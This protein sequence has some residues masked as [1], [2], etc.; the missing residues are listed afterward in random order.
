LKDQYREVKRAICG[1]GE[2]FLTDEFSKFAVPRD[3]WYDQT[4]KQREK[5][6][7]KFQ[8]SAKEVIV[9]STNMTKVAVEAKHKGRK[10]GQLKRKATAKTSSTPKK[11]R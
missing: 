3:H 8:N 6:Y 2:F 10:P 9:R 1:V 11:I 7:Q 5:H 4:D